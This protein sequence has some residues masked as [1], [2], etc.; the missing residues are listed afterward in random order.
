MFEL[1][2]ISI[3]VEGKEIV[4]D[5]SLV[6][7]EGEVVVLMGPNGSGKSTLVNGV[8]GHP[9]YIIT[10]GKILFDEKNV[11]NSSVEEKAQRGIFLSMQHI[12]KVGGLT[13]AT[14]LHKASK[15]TE[16]VLEYYVALRTEVEEYGINPDM[17]D[18]PLTAGLSGGEKKLSEIIQ[19]IALKPR[20]AVLDEID[21]GVDVDAM[22]VFF[23]AIEKLKEDGTSFL[24]ISHHP[25]LLDHLSPDTVHVMS[26]GKL[27]KSH[28][29][30][31]A[32]EILKYGF[33]K[34]IECEYRDSCPVVKQNKTD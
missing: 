26:D 10:K 18:R 3:I 20:V 23:N 2:N 33:C 17:L 1:K 15:S 31:L 19:L 29:K 14:F 22:K 8:M 32:E 5:V 12:P 27:I 4:S 21:S 34:A 28:G 24:I 7:K 30:E 9:H 6:L 16:S 25:S 13:L 11:T